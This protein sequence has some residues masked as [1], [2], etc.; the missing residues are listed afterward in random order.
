MARVIVNRLWHHHFG[1]GIVST[2]NDL[3]TQGDKPS[4]PELLEWLAGRLVREGWSL[5]KLHRLIVTSAAYVQAGLVS[6]SNRKADP[7]NLLLWQRRPVRL[8]AE[9]FRDALLAVSGRLKPTVGGPSVADVNAPRRSVYL[10]VKRSQ[11]IAFLRL[12]DQPEPL[13]SVGARGVATVA[14]Q[15]LT[16]MNSPFVRSS[17]D[18]LAKRAQA[19]AGN[20]TPEQL[21]DAVT[22]IAL[23]RPASNAERDNILPLLA[24]LQAEAGADA[25]KRAAALAD[26]CQLVLSTNE[27][28]YVD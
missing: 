24:S 14:T 16:M 12:F 8:E 15:S 21:L 4:H 1:R 25:G 28:I 9:A 5:K 26:I 23:G 19:A 22:T 17:A 11:P 18:G 2:P 13:Q 20:G 6:E 7:D 27:F 10:R 3:G